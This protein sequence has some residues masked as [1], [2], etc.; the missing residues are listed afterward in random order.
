MS[1]G[2]YHPDTLPNTGRSNL[3][4]EQYAVRGGVS[5]DRPAAPWSGGYAAMVRGAGL[6]LRR[7]GARPRGHTTAKTTEQY[8]GPRPRD[9]AE[10]GQT[11][12]SSRQKGV[13]I[14]LTREGIC[15]KEKLR[16]G[17][18]GCLGIQ[19]TYPIEVNVKSKAEKKRGIE[20]RT[21]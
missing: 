17:R 20:K 4:N 12:G 18:R 19:P 11:S 14:K 2:E 15:E 8:S 13:T 21:W 9:P 1:G 16:R 10:R 6:G 5:W 7:H 3:T